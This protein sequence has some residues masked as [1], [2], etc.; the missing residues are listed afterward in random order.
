MEDTDPKPLDVTFNVAVNVMAF[1]LYG[2][3]YDPEEVFT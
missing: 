3:P 2:N 1:M